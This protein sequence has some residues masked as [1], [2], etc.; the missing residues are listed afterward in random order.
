VD[1]GGRGQEWMKWIL[2]VDRGERGQEWIL[3]V[4][5]GGRGQENKGMEYNRLGK[6]R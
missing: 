5:R 2:G 4:D 1:R 3:G 6:D